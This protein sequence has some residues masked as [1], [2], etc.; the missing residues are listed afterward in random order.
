MLQEPSRDAARGLSGSILQTL[1]R[2]VHEVA[3]DRI[4]ELAEQLTEEFRLVTIGGSLRTMMTAGGAE[5]LRNR[6]TPYGQRL[7]T[8]ILAADEEAS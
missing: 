7:F 4:V 3:E 5:D 1:R 2:R 8:Y 6:F